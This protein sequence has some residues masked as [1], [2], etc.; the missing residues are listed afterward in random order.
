MATRLPN[1]PPGAL[2]VALGLEFAP[3][4]TAGYLVAPGA[5]GR[6][7]LRQFGC[8]T[9]AAATA[10]L[11]SEWQS[12]ENFL[13][14][15]SPAA[16][17]RPP[18]LFAASDRPPRL[19]AAVVEC[20]YKAP[21]TVVGG[22]IAL[23]ELYR[24]VCNKRSHGSV[25]DDVR[26]ALVETVQRFA[27]VEL[28]RPP[29]NLWRW[30]LGDDDRTGSAPLQGLMTSLTALI[31]EGR[32]VLLAHIGET[33]AY[34]V[35]AHGRSLQRLAADHTLAA[36]PGLAQPPRADR[37]PGADLPRCV[38]GCGELADI[39]IEWF[40]LDP[41]DTLL[42]CSS[43]LLRGNRGEDTIV[44]TLVDCEPAAARDQLTAR[45]S[46]PDQPERMATVVI[47]RPPL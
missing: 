33:A 25:E 37:G 12:A 34:R 10:G 9:G 20:N 17:D 41:G 45:R 4:L 44:R 30:R 47:L 8:T 1:P 38:L 22:T 42:V 29:H 2:Q 7:E 5:A 23:S 46:S 24:H 14:A 26:V 21:V 15:Q 28:V 43:S 27:Q 36:D 13:L 16:S 31:V 40:K 39:Q 18:R 35:A 11:M 6:A 3:L 19:V 32:E